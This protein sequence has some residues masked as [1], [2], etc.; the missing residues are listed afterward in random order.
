MEDRRNLPEAFRMRMKRLLGTEWEAFQASY[1]KE[2]SY[3][4]RRN[5]LKSSGERFMAQMPYT[6]E[7]V[8]WAEEGYYY[9]AEEQPGK[10]VLHEAGVYYVCGARR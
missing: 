4:L 2:R 1:D 5:P 8:S 9:Q 10:D 3:G 6:L 7:K